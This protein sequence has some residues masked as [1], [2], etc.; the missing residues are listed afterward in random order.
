MSD[1]KKCDKCG[2]L[3]EVKAGSVT[4]DVHIATATL[5]AEGGRSW[6]GWSEVDFCMNC[7][8]AV[9][10]AIGKAIQR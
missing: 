9:L 5:D 10:A 6:S 3:Y 2:A 1:A 8:K 4:L 7:G